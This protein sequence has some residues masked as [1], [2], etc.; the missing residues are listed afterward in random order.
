MVDPPVLGLTTS[1]TS[2][3]IARGLI[4]LGNEVVSADF[5]QIHAVCLDPEGMFGRR[6]ERLVILWR[7]EDVFEADV[8]AWIGGDAQA[9]ERLEAGVSELVTMTAATSANNQLAVVLGLPPHPVGFG[10]DPLD[11]TWSAQMAE[12]VAFARRCAWTTASA[13]P[14]I[15]LIDHGRLVDV[16]GGFG[17]HDRRNQMLYRQPY[18]SGFVKM[19]A[20]EVDREV[21]AFD[22][23]PPKAIMLDADNTLWGGIVGEDGVAGLEIGGT[24]PGVAYQRFQLA[25]KALQ[26]QGVLLALVSKNE[27]DAVGEVFRQRSEMLLR[28]GDFAATRVNWNRKSQ[29][30]LEI[31][32]QFAIGLDSVVFVD[33]SPFEIA[34]VSAALPDVRCLTVP[35]DIE[36]LPDLVSRTGWFRGRQVSTE[37]LERTNMMQT[38]TLRREVAASAQSHEEFLATLDLT[39]E[40]TRDDRDT[41]QRVTQLINKTN[42]FNVTTI[43]RDEAEVAAL[44][45]DER[46]T[47]YAATVDD[48]FGSY[49]L[50]VVAIVQWTEAEALI[51]TLLMS[52]RVLKRGVESAMLATISADAAKRDVPVLVGRF[53]PT[54]K[55]GQ[56]A[57]LY[58]AHGFT[59]N[60]DGTF[61]HALPG[62]LD[63]PKH[64]SVLDA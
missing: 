26:A 2:E 18:T 43:R 24:F 46:T 17:A 38:E 22:S 19:L 7:L 3:P 21:R 15:R 59:T 28:E 27:P 4:E 11:P 61:R 63:V 31:A 10:V 60:D 20:G 35:E 62:T 41:I 5:N 16:Y 47:V 45:G 49:G 9:R 25:M 39:V 56:V 29:S 40:V 64:I 50:V 54:D 6:V 33:D 32:E 8:M 23:P 48:R 57:D 34:E 36:D 44:F 37:D 30:I 53:T 51:D 52:C 13:T 1:F 12:L 55:N 14:G 42:Q 58:V